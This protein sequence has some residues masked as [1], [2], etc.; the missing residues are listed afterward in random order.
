M[1]E[2]EAVGDVV[3]ILP[4]FRCPGDRGNRLLD[5][6]ALPKAVLFIS[7]IETGIILELER[8][9]RQRIDN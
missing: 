4:V 1:P 8:E 5:V 3:Q 7:V 9:R 6:Q 2:N